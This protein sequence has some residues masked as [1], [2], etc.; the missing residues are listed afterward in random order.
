L[1]THRNKSVKIQPRSAKVAGIFISQK[2]CCMTIEN[3]QKNLG[4]LV[5]R[6]QDKIEL[7]RA[8]AAETDASFSAFLS[9]VRS[10]LE[11]LQKKENWRTGIAM[12]DAV[13]TSI[14]EKEASIDPSADQVALKI[15]LSDLVLKL[16]GLL[17]KPGR[18][19]AARPVFNLLVLD[20]LRLIAQQLDERRAFFK[21]QG[22]DLDEEPYFIVLREEQEPVSTQY[23]AA[24]RFNEVQSTAADLRVFELTHRVMA[25]VGDFT[26]LFKVY[27]GLTDN[28]RKR[29]PE[30]IPPP[31]KLV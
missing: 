10:A 24:L 8:T 26:A 20:R 15:S 31:A 7:A 19:E 12:P 21:K 5:A 9:N 16:E 2:H 1:L 23:R 18:Q 13:W 6:C 4:E 28:M 29:L 3:L 27:K 30:T 25:V 11:A 14:E 22:L 17:L